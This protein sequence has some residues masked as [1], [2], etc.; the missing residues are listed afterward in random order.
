MARTLAAP[1]LAAGLSAAVLTAC[2]GT[3]ASDG[4]TELT[5]WSHMAG[6]PE[7]LEVLDRI[8]DDFNDSQDEYRI[9]K[10]DFP[11][12]AYN[13]AV[14][15]AAA[16]GDLPCV[17]SVDGPVMP[18]WA[19]SNYLA[20]LE[21]PD[22]TVE[23]LLP[24]VVGRYQDEVYSVGH[25][26]VA[27]AIYA[28][29]S[30]LEE[31]DIRV[32]DIEEPWTLEEFDDVLGTLDDTGDYDH[33]FD[34]GTSGTGEW[35]SYAYSPML[36]S[37]GGDLIDRDTMDTAEGALN[38]PE[39]VEFGEWWQSLFDRGLVNPRESED[40]LEFTEGQAALSWDGSWAAVNATEAFGDDVLFLPPPDLGTGPVTGG[41]SW[42]WALS[43]ACADPDGAREYI[44]FSLRDE[45][46]ADFSSAQ[47][48]I[49]ATEG[50]A[51]MTEGYAEDGPYRVFMEYSREYAVL[52]PETPAYP[53]IS[54]VFEGTA[55]DILNG[56]DP[57]TALDSAV[58]RIDADLAQNDFYGS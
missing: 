19:W 10:E 34:V 31:N 48:L 53:V 33:V 39:A 52:R 32:P 23:R 45:Y 51:E 41:A 22:E 42:Q 57:A 9:V 12:D 44:E 46:I 11:Q 3:G 17:L 38:G 16:S 35:W 30:V 15:G 43:S 5:L 7:E 28:R 56:T 14:T 50:A 55:Q 20:P 6:N 47:G 40:R 36:Q 27:L 25:F 49:P 24:S 21:L 4:R 29:A 37:F 1:I 13:E 54:S 18:G 8:I 26:D 2:S 58:D